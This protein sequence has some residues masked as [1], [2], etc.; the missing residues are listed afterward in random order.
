MCISLKEFLSTENQINGYMDEIG[1]I[2]SFR[3]SL[4]TKQLCEIS[5]NSTEGIWINLTFFPIIVLTTGDVCV[6]MVT[7]CYLNL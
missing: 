2:Y 6:A 5:E 7:D 1:L 4:Y 3:G